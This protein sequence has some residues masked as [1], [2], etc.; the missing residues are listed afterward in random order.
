MTQSSDGVIVCQGLTKHYGA[1]QALHGLDL[2][3]PPHSI[4][5]FLGP[6]GAG[7]TTAIKLLAGLTRPTSGRAWMV[8]QEIGTHSLEMR[9]RIG[10]LAQE[11]RFYDWMTGRETL[12]YVGHFFPPGGNLTKRVVEVL[13]LVDLTEAAD[14][15][16]GTY[17]GGMKQRLGIAQAL[18]GQPE[19]LLLDEPA[20]SLDPIGRRD[21]LQIME[22]LRQE[23]T[24][25]YSTHILDDVERVSDTVAILNKGQLITQAK[26]EELLRRFTRSLFELEVEGDTAGLQAK[27]ERLPWVAS[28]GRKAPASDQPAG[29]TVLEVR[30]RE[31][32]TAKR[33]LPRL[34]LDEGLILVRCQ[35]MVLDLEAV[36]MRLVEGEGGGR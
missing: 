12:A 13:D 36:F 22:R 35:P 29:S 28:V 14:R 8:G 19:V 34:A 25:F 16:V 1:I 24:I 18:V 9:R 21:V 3:V 11:P 2:V 17:S 7:K 10:Y 26:T 33:Q 15:K 23:T 5:G 20:A 4:F 6:N 31:V 30:V 27:L 32:E